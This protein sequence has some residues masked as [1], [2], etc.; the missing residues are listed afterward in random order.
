ML[1]VSIKERELN[2]KHKQW[3]SNADTTDDGQAKIVLG[4]DGKTL[5]ITRKETK[6]TIDKGMPLKE[7]PR[8]DLYFDNSELTKLLLLSC[9]CMEFICS[10]KEE[11][12]VLKFTP[13]TPQQPP[14]LFHQK[15]NGQQNQEEGPKKKK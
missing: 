11:Y 4:K 3:C 2:K 10:R 5:V 9:V 7:I 8:L 12:C 13:H 6:Y 1:S 14:P 15:Q